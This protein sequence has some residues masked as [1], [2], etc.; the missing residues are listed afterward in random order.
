MEADLPIYLENQSISF[1]STL[2]SA[3]Q[4]ALR[5]YILKYLEFLH[6][7]GKHVLFSLPE[8]ESRSVQE[9]VDF[10]LMMKDL[11]FLEEIRGTRIDR[12]NAYLFSTWL[13]A[14][15]HAGVDINRSSGWHQVVLAEYK[16]SWSDGGADGHAARAR[17]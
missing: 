4:D 3:S 7:A 6:R 15:M 14:A 13:K 10:S 11:P 9:S 1:P 17:G 2:D 8:F 5:T 12:I 16:S